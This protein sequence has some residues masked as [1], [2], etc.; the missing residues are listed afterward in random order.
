MAAKVRKR[1]GWQAPSRPRRPAQIAPTRGT[2][3]AKTTAGPFGRVDTCLNHARPDHQATA[4]GWSKG[5]KGLKLMIP[6]SPETHIL[7]RLLCWAFALLGLAIIGP[8]LDDSAPDRP[9][10]SFAVADPDLHRSIA[11]PALQAT[12][13]HA[14]HQSSVASGPLDAI[15]SLPDNSLAP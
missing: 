5:I 4:G 14:H 11:G 9:P 1:V 6:S 12:G 3:Y 2:R 10:A 7:P 8:V 13:P 15:N